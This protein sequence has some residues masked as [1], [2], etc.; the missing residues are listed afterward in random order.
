MSRAYTEE[1][2]KNKILHHL[3]HLVDYWSDNDIIKRET[4]KE[5]MQGL[6]HSMLAF[7]GGRT[8]GCCAL[9][10]VA[11]PHEDD[12]EYHISEGENYFEDGTRVSL[13]SSDW[14]VFLKKHGY[15]KSSP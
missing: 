6:V 1:E 8:L 5:R 9:D 12:K 14:F 3:A 7:M 11:A 10:I 2:I 13:D 15:I 4:T